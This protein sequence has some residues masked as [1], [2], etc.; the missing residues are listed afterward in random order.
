MPVADGVDGLPSGTT[1]INYGL[2]NQ[3][4]VRRQP[5]A[6]G[7]VSAV[8]DI[9][10]VNIT[11]TYYSNASAAQFDPQYQTYTPSTSTAS[12]FSPVQLA[13]TA[14]PVD[15][16]SGSFRMEI[17]PKYK[18]IRTLGANGTVASGIAQISA[19]W[20]KRE[21]IPGLDGFSAADSSNFLNVS[22]T[23]RRHD[24]HI[25]GTY[26]MNVDIMNRSFLN[27][28][29]L[30]YYNSQCCGV[31]VD[32]QSITTP[33]LNVPSNRHFRHLVHAGRHRILLESARLVRWEI[34]AAPLAMKLIRDRRARRVTRS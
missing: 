33:L 30:A 3:I 23:I 5:T 12:S 27:Q 26:T 29:V 31:S 13:A 32:W 6:P 7:G 9:I 19:G 28:R 14:R 25:G 34:I 11:Q 16:V 2:S 24:N 1:T 17:D 10:D 4:L 21:V 20:S 22:T 8:R 18:A 15:I